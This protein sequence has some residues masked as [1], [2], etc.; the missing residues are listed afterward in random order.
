V[1]GLFRLIRLAMEARGMIAVCE[2]CGGGALICSAVG[3]DPM[4][5][6]APVYDDEF[7]LLGVCPH[8]KR[9]PACIGHPGDARPVKTQPQRTSEAES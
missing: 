7:D 2:R 9:C 3:K 8:L 6:P 4:R 1:I 5:C